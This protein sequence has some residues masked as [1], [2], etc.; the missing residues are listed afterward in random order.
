MK[1]IRANLTYANV[2]VTVLLFVVL[3]GGAYAATNLS[4]NSVGSKQ[5]KKNSIKGIDVRNDGLSGSDIKESTL[6][7][8]A[9]AQ[10]IG[11]S[12]ALTSCNPTSQTFVEC[13]T[14]TLILPDRG[15]V[16]L[17]AAGGQ[18][19]QVSIARGQC[20]LEADGE[21]LP[22][23]T[24]KPGEESSDNTSAVGTNGFAITTVTPSLAAGQHSFR[25]TCNENL[26]DSVYGDDT[27]SAVALA[28]N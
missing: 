4:K 26:G 8:P 2:M 9:S 28:A 13:G 15:R 14:V 27:I 6:K 3:G 20:R 7:L 16:L 19:S 21:V 25:M 17:T 10:A 5:I 18:F 12:G 22:N 24:I 23:T 1:R 11:R